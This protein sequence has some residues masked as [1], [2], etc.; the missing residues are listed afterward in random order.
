MF[1]DFDLIAGEGGLEAVGE[2][3]EVMALSA[4]RVRVTTPTA[5]RGCTRELLGPRTSTSATTWVPAKM[6]SG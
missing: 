3:D 5:P 2:A 1:Q 4:G 6:L